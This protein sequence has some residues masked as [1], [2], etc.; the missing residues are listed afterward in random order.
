MEC[1]FTGGVFISAKWNEARIKNFIISVLRAGSRK[2]PPRSA[3]L[4]AAKTE[5]KLNPKSNRIAQHY[6]C[7]V[8]KKEFPATGIQVDHLDPVV[9]PAMGFVDWNTY[10]PRLFC[11][12][13][14]LQAICK[15]C[16][17]AKSNKE[18]KQRHANLKNVKNK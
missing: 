14:N 5:K 6:K 9:D 4:N 17:T 12:E 1:Y 2:W 18:K 15:K 3:V 7:N 8:C 10:I 16:H 11:D 13:D